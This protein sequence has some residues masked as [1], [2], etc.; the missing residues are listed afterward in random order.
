MLA[1]RRSNM[2]CHLAHYGARWSAAYL[3]TNFV[4]HA[5]V[6]SIDVS[7]KKYQIVDISVIA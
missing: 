7:E 1:G 5:V 4:L 3:A 2:W 6:R